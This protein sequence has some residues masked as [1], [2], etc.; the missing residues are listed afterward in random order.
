MS[1]SFTNLHCSAAGPRPPPMRLGVFLAVVVATFIA[2]GVGFTSADGTASDNSNKRVALDKIIKRFRG[3][4]RLGGEERGVTVPV[5]AYVYAL[6]RP[7]SISSN[8]VHAVEHHEPL[9]KWATALIVLLSLGVVSGGAYG[10]VK[11]TQSLNLSK[12]G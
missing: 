7:S 1:G 8:I 10:A 3:S 9:P 2:S 4:Q 6:N 12:E 5:A 11:L